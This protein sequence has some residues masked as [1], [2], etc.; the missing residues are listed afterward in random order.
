M[1]G[2]AVNVTCVPLQIVVAG[3][4][5]ATDGIKTG[6]TVIIL[7]S[8]TGVVAAQVAFETISTFTTSLFA[9]LLRIN[10]FPVSPTIKMLFKYHLY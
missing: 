8:E 9:K 3:A 6:L 4:V 1:V 5:K 2:V 10:V 7:A